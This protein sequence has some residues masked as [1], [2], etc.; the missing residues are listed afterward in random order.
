MEIK[1]LDR[2]K[3]RERFTPRTGLKPS[4]VSER[5]LAP[6][7]HTSAL[8]SRPQNKVHEEVQ[9]VRYACEAHDDSRMGDC[10]TSHGGC[11]IIRRASPPRDAIHNCVT[12]SA[13]E[14][15]Y[16]YPTCLAPYEDVFSSPRLRAA[17]EYLNLPAAVLMERSMKL[18]GAFRIPCSRKR[19]QGLAVFEI[20]RSS[21]NS[22]ISGILLT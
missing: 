17:L 5:K 8:V 21:E 3:E 19:R 11:N 13:R 14:I 16:L 9:L 22:D 15:N 7:D 10:I 4:G 20:P 18:R 6:R 1:R 2:G 12:I